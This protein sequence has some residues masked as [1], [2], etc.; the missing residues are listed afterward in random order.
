MHGTNQK[1]KKERNKHEK[2]LKGPFKLFSCYLTLK[3]DE[4]NS[5]IKI[6]CKHVEDDVHRKRENIE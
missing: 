3:N 2:N 4:N 6:I 5:D 1:N